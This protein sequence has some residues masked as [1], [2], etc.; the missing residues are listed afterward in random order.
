MIDGTEIH[1]YTR[2]G[3]RP[4]FNFSIPKSLTADG[5][6]NLLFSCEKKDNG[7]GER[8]TQVAEIW[9]IKK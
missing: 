6:I 4:I 5:K 2:M 1:G 7:Q 8:G 9:I 3:T